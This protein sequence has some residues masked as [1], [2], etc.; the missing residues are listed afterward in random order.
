MGVFFFIA[1]TPTYCPCDMFDAILALTNK[2]LSSSHIHV[3]SSHLEV[4]IPT[5]DTSILYNIVHET[6]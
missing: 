4:E 3:E 6:Y 5:S 1:F 2:M